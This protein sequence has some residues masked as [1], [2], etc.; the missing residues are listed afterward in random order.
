MRWLCAYH[1][2]DVE[3][4][5]KEF[6]ELGVGN[7]LVVDAQG[8]RVLRDVGDVHVPLG[9]DDA[10]AIVCAGAS[11]EVGFKKDV[12][13]HLGNLL[14]AVHKILEEELGGGLI[15]GALPVVLAG[16]SELASVLVY[17][18]DLAPELEGPVGGL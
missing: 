16:D 2:V 17:G 14:V 15:V 9:G 12:R 3:L 11:C 18:G 10:T 8:V 13:A 4:L 1:D 6:E 5:N 7:S